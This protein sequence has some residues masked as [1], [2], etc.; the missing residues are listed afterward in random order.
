MDAHYQFLLRTRRRLGGSVSLL[1][2]VRLIY[3]GGSPE[4][5]SVVYA[6]VRMAEKVPADQTRRAVDSSIAKGGG[7]LLGLIHPNHSQDQKDLLGR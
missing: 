3:P 6:P 5:T 7:G 2:D 1:T 4:A